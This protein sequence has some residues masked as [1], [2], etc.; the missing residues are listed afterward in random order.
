MD[1]HHSKKTILSVRELISTDSELI[2]NYWL[3][4]RPEFLTGMGVD[5]AKVPTRSEWEQMLSAQLT[6]S[7]KDKKSYCLIWLLNQIPVGHCNINKILFGKEGYMHIHMW[8]HNDRTKNLGTSFIRMCLPYFFTNYSVEKLYCEPYALNQAPNKTLQ[9]LGFKFVKEYT[10]TPGWLNFEQSVN[11]WEL[12]R[13][14]FLDL[15][16]S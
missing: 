16:E 15:D 1:H 13:Q 6:Q 5:L 14:Q 11:L 4:A 7:Y 10:T 8:N 3:Q 2:T 12:S 9:K